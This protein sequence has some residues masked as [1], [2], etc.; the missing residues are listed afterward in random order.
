VEIDPELMRIEEALITDRCETVLQEM[1]IRTRGGRLE[2]VSP[3]QAWGT[4]EAHRSRP[5][6]GTLTRT[7]SS[8]SIAP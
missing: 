4:I 7:T 1:R 6:R 8:P 3:K 5:T 2:V